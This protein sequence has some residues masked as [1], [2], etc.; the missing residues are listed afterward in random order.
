MIEIGLDHVELIKVGQQR[1]G[2]T[3]GG[4]DSFHTSRN[5]RHFARAPTPGNSLKN[6][7][8]GFSHVVPPQKIW[9]VRK[10]L[11]DNYGTLRLPRF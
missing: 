6:L 1:G 4:A 3:V 7:P 10:T 11:I 9:S 8:R 2:G 5:L